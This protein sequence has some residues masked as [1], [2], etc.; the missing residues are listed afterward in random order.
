LLWK[1]AEIKDRPGIGRQMKDNTNRAKLALENL[2]PDR[3]CALNITTKY[4]ISI[5][6]E[7]LEL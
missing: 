1:F 4:D 5:Q 3:L 2:P 7:S 6:Q